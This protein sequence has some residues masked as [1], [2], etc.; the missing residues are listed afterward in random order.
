MDILNAIILGIIQGLTEFLPVSSSGH[1]EI[2]EFFIESDGSLL[3]TVVLHFATAL[4]TMIIFW[5]DIKEIIFGLIRFKNNK[6]FSFSLNILISMIP[7]VFVG[8]L[9]E[10]QVEMLFNNKLTLVGFMLIATGVLL[11]IADKIKPREPS[12][13]LNLSNS[14]LIGIAQA[15][16]ILPGMSR[17]GSTISTAIFLGINKEKA[18][19]IN[20]AI[21]DSK[22]KVSSQ[23]LDE[24]IRVSGKKIDDLQKTFQ[25]VRSLKEL[26]IDVKMENMKS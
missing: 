21:K 4:S 10:E 8:L 13:E 15:I 14:L 18:K 11:F 20:K 3:M 16:A 22:I 5:K 19:I 24:K 26:E 2:V 23:Y 12:K 7:A 9:F 17:S 1:L 25:M 6:A